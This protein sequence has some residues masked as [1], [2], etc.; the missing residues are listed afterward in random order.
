MG[1]IDPSVAIYACLFILV[2]FVGLL[3]VTTAGRRDRDSNEAIRARFGSVFAAC[4]V[5]GAV[6][7]FVLPTNEF[8]REG[9]TS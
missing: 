8:W 1:L 2:S 5:S 3:Y 4:V 6:V 9:K 7:W